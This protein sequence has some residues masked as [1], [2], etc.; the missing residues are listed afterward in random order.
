M[1]L[2][3]NFKILIGGQ[4]DLRHPALLFEHP[5]MKHWFGSLQSPLGPNKSFLFIVHVS[6]ANYFPQR[7]RLN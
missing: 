3:Q 4:V 2:F 1:Y 5:W 7:A 6:I